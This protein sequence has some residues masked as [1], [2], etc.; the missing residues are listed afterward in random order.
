[1]D[2]LSRRAV[3]GAAAGAA[4]LV[5]VGAADA[6]TPGLDRKVS[7]PLRSHYAGSIGR[8]FTARQ[9][10]RTVRLRLTAIRDVVPTSARQRSRCFILVFAPVGKVSAPDAIYLLRR[11]GVRTHRL[12]LSAFGT[13]H[14]MQAIINRPT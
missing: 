13:R 2:S 10:G 9:G 14:A 4:G 8:I 12:F 1:M 7:A 6:R 5:A 11:S 3:V